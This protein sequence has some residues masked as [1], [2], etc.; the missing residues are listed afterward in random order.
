MCSSSHFMC[1]SPFLQ[2]FP[3]HGRG[4]FALP[5]ADPPPIF[6]FRKRKRAAAGPKEKP[7]GKQGEARPFNQPFSGFRRCRG[8]AV[9]FPRFPLR[10]ALP[11][12]AACVC[13]GPKGPKRPLRGLRPLRTPL[14]CSIMPASRSGAWGSSC[15]RVYLRAS[16]FAARCLG[17]RPS[18][19]SP[20]PAPGAAGER[21]GFPIPHRTPR[22]LP[23][24]FGPHSAP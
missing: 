18:R 16:R 7:F 3:C 6:F 8:R 12:R 14:M 5:R 1:V 15:L 21:A 22:A 13:R 2:G 10:C 23:R 20:D 11:W 17:G 9:L 4:G 19:I 24:P